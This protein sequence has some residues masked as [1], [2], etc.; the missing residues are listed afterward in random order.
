MNDWID[1][2]RASVSWGD[3]LTLGTLPD[4]TGYCLMSLPGEQHVWVPGFLADL[5]VAITRARQARQSID[6]ANVIVMLLDQQASDYQVEEAFHVLAH[7]GAGCD[8]LYPQPRVLRDGLLLRM[9]E[10]TVLDALPSGDD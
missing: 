7:A 10:G 8:F 5:P 9:S 3:R 2:F 4:G 1:E 6:G